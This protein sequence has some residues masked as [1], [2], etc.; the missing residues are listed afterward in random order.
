MTTVRP[1]FRPAELPAAHGGDDDPVAAGADQFLVEFDYP[2]RQLRAKQY[3]YE[4]GSYHFNWHPEIE[5]LMVLTGHVEVCSAG[6][7]AT[8][9]PGDVVLINSGEAHAT[10][11]Q[12][13]NS[14]ALLLHLNPGH[15]SGFFDN[16][17]AL[18]FSCVT[19]SRTRNSAPFVELRGHL[20]QLMLT[21]VDQTPAGLVRYHAGLAQVGR[22]LVDHFDPVLVGTHKLSSDRQRVQSLDRMLRFIDRHYA[23]R[24]T[25]AR[26][27]AAAGYSPGYV[28][29]VFPRCLG[30]R[31]SQYITRVRLRQATRYLADPD[32]KVVDIAIRSGFPDVKAFNVAFRKN[33][34]KSPTEYR[35]R[36]TDDTRVVDSRFKERFVPRSDEAARQILTKLAAGLGKSETQSAPH[37]PLMTE[38]DEIATLSA[39]L[40]KR[41]H[42]IR[43]SMG[44]ISA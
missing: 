7:V 28:S 14:K 9:E 27:G 29:Q 41:L 35:R 20:A 38:L 33:F 10:M 18:T 26:I 16:P 12:A 43:D 31:T 44:E 8:H 39:D 25:L 21:G 37:E 40:T 2:E 42:E 22:L 32:L 13:P 17:A 11:A 23:E 1:Q 6:R 34:G 4:I 24:L 3:V 15:F 30:M 5:L 36:M 19:D